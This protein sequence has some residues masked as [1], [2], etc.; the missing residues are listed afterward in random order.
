MPFGREPNSGPFDLGLRRGAP[1]EIGALDVLTRLEI[2]VVDEEV[3]DCVEF[4]A[5]HIGE[6]SDVI[7]AVVT[8]W[9][10]DHLVVAAGV[11]DH[12]EHPDR[13]GQDDDTGMH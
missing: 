13:A 4:V 1:H 12:L 7:P 11:V 10:A 6:V 3:L 5:G 8:G 9:N 2:L